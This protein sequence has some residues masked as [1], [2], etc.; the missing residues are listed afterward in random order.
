MNGTKY[1]HNKG[2]VH[3]DLKPE[4]I[5]FTDNTYTKIKIVDLGCGLSE[6]QLN[7]Y[8]LMQTRYS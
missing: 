2:I 1:L 4:N 5:V 7:G 6:Y 3:S 8:T